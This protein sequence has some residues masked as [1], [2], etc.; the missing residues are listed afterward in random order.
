MARRADP[1][2]KPQLIGQIIEVLLDRPLSAVTLRS[3]ADRLGVSTFTLVYHFG[4]KDGLVAEIVHAI[5]LRQREALD[6]GWGGATIDDC[7][8]GM[9]RF[10]EW[11]LLPG[12]RQLQRLL[13]EAALVES[14]REDT[15]AVTRLPLERWR[16]IVSDGLLAVGAPRELALQESS[17]IVN[18]MSGLQYDLIVTGDVDRVTVA[19]DYAMVGYRARIVALASMPG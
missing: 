2:R 12:N 14:L 8:G 4:S 5:C 16:E 18:T 15:E 13:F 17:M 10:W 19:F 9:R 11:I 3:I 1:T 6:L 7:V